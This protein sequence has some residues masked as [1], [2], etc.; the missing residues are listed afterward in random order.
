MK[1]G[2]RAK[3]KK[4]TAPVARYAQF[5]NNAEFENAISILRRYLL[6]GSMKGVFVV[7]IDSALTL[8]IRMLD[9]GDKSSYEEFAAMCEGVSSCHV[10]DHLL[11]LNRTLT[12]HR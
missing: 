3:A 4:M 6:A 1:Q 5:Q 10:I 9:M 8:L 2:R 11:T 12:R 7:D